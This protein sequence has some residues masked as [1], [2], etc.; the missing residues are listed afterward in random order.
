MSN[1]KILISV[2]AIV[3]FLLAVVLFF[4]FFYNPSGQENASPSPTSQQESDQQATDT[5]NR[6]PVNQSSEGDSDEG[7]TILTTSTADTEL[8]QKQD[9]NR[10]DLANMASSFAER[11]GSYSTHSNFDNI[12]NLEI[13]MTE[14]MQEW[15]EEFVQEQSQEDS[16][17]YS[18]VTTNT[19]ST[20]IIEFDQE[21]GTAEVVVT[22]QR[23]ESTGSR[24]ESTT[25]DQDLTLEFVK[26]D[27]SWK[28][29]R[30]EWEER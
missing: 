10:V 7:E 29:D 15:A 20:D 23:R 27:D 25:Y 5:S 18:G 4:F 11:F 30:A 2:I 12:K 1:K 3:I 19:I 28:V 8:S 24:Q 22:T 21:G 9:F 14:D 13:F 26:K 17:E 6:I 16:R